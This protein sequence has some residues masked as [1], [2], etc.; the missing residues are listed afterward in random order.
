MKLSFSLLAFALLA[1]S[2]T[3]E[4]INIEAEDADADDDQ[5]GAKCLYN[6]HFTDG[7]LIIDQPGTYK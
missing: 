3:A 7:T 4:A 6:N 5:N 1:E 2:A